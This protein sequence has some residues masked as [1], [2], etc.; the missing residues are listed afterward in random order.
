VDKSLVAIVISIFALVIS[1]IQWFLSGAWVTIRSRSGI[2]VDQP[3]HPEVI[4]L[5]ANNRGRTATWIEQ[6]GWVVKGTLHGPIGWTSGPT[7]AYRLDGYAEARWMMDYRE[8]RQSLMQNHPRPQLHYWDLVPYVRPGSSSAF[9]Y[10]RSVMRIWEDGQPVGP[11][12]AT[13]QWWKRFS[14][15]HVRSSGRHGTGWMRRQHLP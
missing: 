8:A 13:S 5:V 2:V 7:L 9:K 14:P 4:I 3:E 1:V 11:D 15:W 12:P 10:G 6:W